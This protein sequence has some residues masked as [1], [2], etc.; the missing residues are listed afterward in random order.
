MEPRTYYDILGVSREANLDDI[1]S[2]K[3][4]LAKVYHPDANMHTPIDTTAHMQEI[5]EA[6]R[7]LS[8]PD[9]RKQ[10]DETLIGHCARIFRTFTVEAPGNGDDVTTSFVTYWNAASQLNEIVNKSRILMHCPS[11]HDKLPKKI[12]HWLGLY[13]KQESD[14]ANELNRLSLQAIQYIAL[15]RA[16]EIPMNYWQPESMNWVL[17]HWGQ[18]QSSDY[19]ILFSKYEV[20]IEQTKSSAEKLRLKSK[21]KQFHNNLK[22]LLNYAVS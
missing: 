1:T 5:L 8:D 10:Y 6:Y 11:R 21:N 9:K 17:V 20:H 13:R 3:N 22:K 19:S 14:I 18:K 15:L 16:A 2:A 12:L 7:T 4:A